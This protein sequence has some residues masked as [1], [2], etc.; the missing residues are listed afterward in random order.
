ML[1][2]PRI[3]TGIIIHRAN[4]PRL[5]ARAGRRAYTGYRGYRIL[6]PVALENPKVHLIPVRVS[7][8]APSPPLLLFMFYTSM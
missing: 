8:A 4:R 1:R 5:G 3:R 2:A 7:V 6:L